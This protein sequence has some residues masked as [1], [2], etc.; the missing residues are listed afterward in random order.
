MTTPVS[1]TERWFR[2]YRP[3]AEAD[4]RLVCFPHGGG[5]A[6][7]YRKWATGLPPG[8]ELA[9][10]QYPGRED[11]REE[12]PIDDMAR[13]AGEVAEAL[14]PLADRP[15]ALF[16]HSLGAA[17]AFEVAARLEPRL[18]PRL[19]AL[20]VSGRWAPQLEQPGTIHLADDD[21]LWREIRR[22]NG[23][24]ELLVDSD[25]LRELVL[26]VL[27]NDYR[28]SETYEP[29]PAEPLR[30]PIVAFT[31]TEDPEVT[32]EDVEGWR[33]WTTSDFELHVFPGHHFYLLDRQQDVLAVVLT[34]LRKAVPY[35][36]LWP[37]GP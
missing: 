32:V 27:R 12:E 33:E 28:L 25:E 18:G 5:A 3:R 8:V 16:G 30:I 1:A 6:S 4:V 35:M 11:R 29:S 37:S 36:A 10:V 22:L 21:T 24:H 15:V 23:T 13:L 19:V 17:I 2:R 31:G 7:F 14:E 26:P 9:V 20:L 34:A